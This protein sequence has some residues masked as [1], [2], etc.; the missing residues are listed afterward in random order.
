MSKSLHVSS[1]FNPYLL[2]KTKEQS[3]AR[4]RCFTSA[5]HRTRPSVTFVTVFHG[6]FCPFYCL[7]SADIA[8]MEWWR[9]THCFSLD[10]SGLL[11]WFV[12]TLHQMRLMLESAGWF[13]LS[14][15]LLFCLSAGGWVALR[16]VHQGSLLQPWKIRGEFEWAFKMSHCYIASPDTHMRKNKLYCKKNVS[17]PVKVHVRISSM[18][19]TL[20]L[21][22]SISFNKDNYRGIQVFH[23]LIKFVGVWRTKSLNHKHPTIQLKKINCFVSPTNKMAHR[24]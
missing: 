18:F 9:D 13:I 17:S 6:F 2:L 12:V 5:R 8:L 3:A 15:M 22:K 21:M 20:Q 4:D 14:L 24:H 19:A 10:L 23:Y 1:C 11:K 16:W 7:S